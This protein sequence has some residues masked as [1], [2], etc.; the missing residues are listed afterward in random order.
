MSRK[1]PGFN[2]TLV[3]L[4]QAFTLAQQRDDVVGFNPTL[5][6]LR[7]G[8]GWEVSSQVYVFQSHAGS[9]EAELG[10]L[11]PLVPLGQ[12]QSHA[13]SIEAH[14][15]PPAQIPRP[16]FQSHAGSIEARA[17]AHRP[18]LQARFQSHAGSIEART[19]SR[20]LWNL[21]SSFNPTLVRLRLVS[22]ARQAQNWASKFQSHAGSIEAEGLARE[23]DPELQFQSHAG[24]IEAGSDRPGDLP[25]GDVSIPRWF[26]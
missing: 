12:F 6:R 15:A 11:A 3:R 19:L 20:S 4:R 22:F 23:E 5:V 21:P 25:P 14:R 13:G 18:L 8:Y 2:P 24:S 16:Q 17:A 10:D 26:D 1:R 9:I 7:P